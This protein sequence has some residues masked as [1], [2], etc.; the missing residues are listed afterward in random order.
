MQLECNAGDICTFSSI[1]VSSK[2]PSK[3]H[4]SLMHI[5]SFLQWNVL[6]NKWG[7]GSSIQM[8]SFKLPE[9]NIWQ[10]FSVY[11]YIILK[12]LHLLWVNLPPLSCSHFLSIIA[13][14]YISSFSV[15]MSSWDWTDSFSALFR[16]RKQE[17]EL[18]NVHHLV[19]D[20]KF[21][22]L[23][24]FLYQS[25]LIFFSSAKAYFF[26]NICTQ[27]FI[28]DKFSPFCLPKSA[29]LMSLVNTMLER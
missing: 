18:E 25:F 7:N 20:C 21:L 10:P 24:L 22:S 3:Q 12:S 6:H 9:E 13:M 17:V 15:H 11:Y 2:Q 26:H 28:T 4:C 14:L 8:Q 1:D 19:Q 29:F 16:Q 27:Y 5:L 23:T